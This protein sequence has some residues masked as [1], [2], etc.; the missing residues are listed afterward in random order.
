MIR[1]GTSGWSYEHW[2]SNFYPESLPKKKAFEYYQSQFDTVELNVS[3]YRLVPKKTYENWH[4]TVNED[5]L[6]AVKGSRYITHI[7]RLKDFEASL[8][9]FFQTVEG[10]SGNLGPVLFQLP[11]NYHKNIAI[12]E[13]FIGGLPKDRRYAFEFRHKSWLEADTYSLLKENNIALAI[14]HSRQFPYSEELT[15]DFVYLRL[16]GPGAL[17]A[18]NY[19]DEELKQFAAKISGWAAGGRDVFAYFNND[20]YAYAPKNA[21]KLKELI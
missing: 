15:A 18:G 16:H 19:S 4:E 21:L 5:F 17:Y 3:F 14:S 2:F 8:D 6:F 20:A 1:I 11:S 9:K 10:L 7:K 12:L 13:L